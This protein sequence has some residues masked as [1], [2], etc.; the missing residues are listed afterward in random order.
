MYK[1]SFNFQKLFKSSND[2]CYYYTMLK[3][4]FCGEYQEV[5]NFRPNFYT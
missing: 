1:C 3:V 2:A 4:K 5:A